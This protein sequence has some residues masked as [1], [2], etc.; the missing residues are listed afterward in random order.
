MAQDNTWR[1]IQKEAE[2]SKPAASAGRSQ[3]FGLM[4]FDTLAFL[5]A[6]AARRPRDY[7]REEIK[8]ETIIG[9]RSKHPIKIKGAAV[10]AAMSFGALSVNAKVAIAKG[11]TM[12]GT[13][14][15][16]G[17][18]GMLPQERGAAQ[19][20]I[21][22]YSTARFGVNEEYLKKAE[23][24]E[25]KFGQGAKPGQGGLL[26]GSKVTEL[27][28][29][30]RG[31][32]TKKIS[33]GETLHS[34]PAHP[35]ILTKNDLKKKIE[36]LRELTDGRPIIVKLGACD[37]WADLPLII[38]ASPDVI[39]ID[40]A[41]GG[42]GAAPKVMLDHTGI[43]TIAALVEARYILD[44]LK[45]PQ[46]LWIGGGIQKGHDIAV[47]LA[48]GADAVFVGSALMRAIGCSNCRLCYKGECPFGIAA[49]KP[50]LAE[51][52]DVAKA[53][54]K[55]RNFFLKCNEEVKMLAAACG[56]DS[57]YSLARKDLRS[58]TSEM[59]YITGIRMPGLP[60]IKAHLLEEKQNRRP[61]IP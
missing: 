60:N 27:I 26:P 57:I 21:A 22:Q 11:A 48:L 42:T 33:A 28:A 15:N 9:K 49:Q 45:A 7:F 16:T 8:S 43:P 25:I 20:L 50:E 37:L 54:E 41:E 29:K 52:L 35:D 12:A 55:V 44:K 3:V 30:T 40:G 2:S 23:A 19:I 34:P 10:V 36:W 32:E 61:E 38:E 24:I 6:Q 13:A 39:A 5:T 51:R 58:L 59:S 1:E 14:D 31:T 53:A 17:E 46:E 18:G 47:C 56:Y 4:S